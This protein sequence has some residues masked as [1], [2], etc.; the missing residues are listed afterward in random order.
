MGL[1]RLNKFI[2]ESGICSRRNADNLIQEGRISVNENIITAL[3]FKIDTDIDT[4]AYDGEKIQNTEKVYYL[5]NKPAG[6]ITTSD[7]ERDRNK[8]VDLVKTKARI[9][10]VGRLDRDTTGVLLLTNDGEFSNFLTH[11]KNKIDREYLA[12]LNKEFDFDNLFSL[13][14]IDLEDG[15]VNILSLKKGKNN[16]QVLIKL[17]E[18]RNRVVKRIFEKLGYEVMKLHRISFAGFTTEGLQLGK[19]KKISYIEITKVFNKYAK[20]NKN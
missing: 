2:A 20:S 12:I 14:Q 8:V 17:A 9:F 4:I 16:S 15:K 18:G 6:Y 10:S 5:L 7:D 1:M 19:F 11:P 3:G 13:K